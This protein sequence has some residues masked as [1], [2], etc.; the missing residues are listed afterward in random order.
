MSFFRSIVEQREFSLDKWEQWLDYGITRFNAN[1]GL[2]EVSESNALGWAV[3]W[4]CVQ[5]KSQDMAK[6]PLQTFR[7]VK[8]ADG[9]GR[10]EAPD[11][12][13]HRLFRVS[14]NPY[15][16]AYIF[17]Q[18]LQMD[19]EI[20]GN[21][22][23]IIER[24]GHNEVTFL[25]HR[26]PSVMCL[27]FKDGALVYKDSS[28]LGVPVY[29]KPEQVFHLKGLT[30]DGVTG[31]SPVAAFREGIQLA[32]QQQRHSTKTMASGVRAP[33]AIEMPA[34]TGPDK[35]REA[36]E[37]FRAAYGGSAN[38]GKTPFFYG[39]MKAV[40][41]GFS[42]ADAQF[43]ESQQFNVEDGCRIWRVP[44]PKVMDFL[45]A[46]YS[47]ITQVDQSYVNDTLRSIQEN[48][49]QEVHFKLM[50]PD[51]R[52]IYYVEHNNYDLL[53]G[54]PQERAQVE[55]AY[56]NAGISQINE[57]RSAHNWDPVKGGDRN[58]V[59]MQN[60][61]LESADQL[62]LAPKPQPVDAKL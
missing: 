56:V 57:V 37:S 4:G 19:L 29:Y 36:A 23:A 3:V 38:V 49:E 62:A 43:L 59:Q 8:R 51:E 21:A 41:L 54:T 61:P 12:P 30:R 7:R 20:S 45:R 40:N 27:E 26:K 11:F 46:T 6:T 9:F 5:V 53:K 24:N 48:W 31:I 50:T 47:N 13:T 25:W 58:R 18:T 1:T 55:V 60:V 22:Y 17:R 14:A 2:P 34:D 28:P 15:M 33:Y 39:G 16:T 44:P 35:A 52:A 10:E 42:N 32:L